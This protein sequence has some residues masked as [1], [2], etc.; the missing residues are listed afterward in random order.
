MKY[1]NS[2]LPRSE[3]KNTFLNF[4]LRPLYIKNLLFLCVNI[5]QVHTNALYSIFI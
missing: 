4:I 2:L 3:T 1:V 5:F